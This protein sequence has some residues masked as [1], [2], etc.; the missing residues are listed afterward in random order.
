MWHPPN[1]KKSWKQKPKAKA[2]ASL[3]CFQ[4]GNHVL[5]SNVFASITNRK[6]TKPSKLEEEEEE[7]EQQQQQR[8]RRQR[9]WVLCQTLSINRRSRDK[10]NWCRV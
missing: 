5:K 8:L 6:N 3:E 9:R 1:L 10:I 2:K 4:L 7:E